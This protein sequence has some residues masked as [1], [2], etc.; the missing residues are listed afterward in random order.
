MGDREE[1]PEE[2]PE[3]GTSKTPDFTSVT[4]TQE[5]QYIKQAFP[6]DQAIPGMMG[7]AAAQE[8]FPY[9]IPEVDA[10]YLRPQEMNI[11][12]Q[13]QNIDNMSQA[14]IRSG[15]DPLAAT[16]QA[17]TAKEQAYQRKQNFDAMGRTRADMFNAQAE[18]QNLICSH[19]QQ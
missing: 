16:I 8:T 4:G 11:Q 15:A 3:G 12:S 2:T 14:A 6:I 10:P 9:A 17:T 1:Q 7:L 13:L 19:V 5:G 18:M